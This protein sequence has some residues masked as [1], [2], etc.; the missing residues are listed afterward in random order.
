MAGRLRASVEG[1][2]YD[3]RKPV[4]NMVGSALSEW[5]PPRCGQ[6]ERVSSLRLWGSIPEAH[7]ASAES[8]RSSWATIDQVLGSSPRPR[9]A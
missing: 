6:T 3:R 5:S 1:T 7:P 4:V 9:G 8:I 2:R